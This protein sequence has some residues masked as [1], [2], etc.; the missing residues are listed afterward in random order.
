[1]D[2]RF[3]LCLH[4]NSVSARVTI[5]TKETTRITTLSTPRKLPPL[6]RDVKTVT[7]ETFVRGVGTRVARGLV[8]S[9]GTRPPEEMFLG[10]DV[11]L[12]TELV[13]GSFV[14]DFGEVGNVVEVV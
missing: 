2:V 5:T 8:T 12:F 1:M 14:I 4:K 7:M 6:S 3:S 10:L 13:N 11:G 9:V